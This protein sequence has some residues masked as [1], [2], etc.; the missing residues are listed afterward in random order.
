MNNKT[1]AAIATAQG[2]GGVGIIR[3]SGEYAFDIADKVFTSTSGKR[4][5]NMPG[6]TASF[7][8]V[9]DENGNSLE[10]IMLIFKKPHSYTGE[11]VVEI[12]CQGGVYVTKSI[13]RAILDNG[14]YPAEAGEFTKRAFLNGKMDL[15]EAESVM[16][17]ISAKNKTA[18]KAANSV[19]EGKLGK[20]LKSVKED[21]LTVAA[22]LSAW[23]DYPEDEIPAVNEEEIF[24]A[25]D[26]ASYALQTLIDE[27][28]RGRVLT[29][30]IDTVIVGKPNVGKSTLMNMLSGSE[31]SI[32]TDI[33][34]TTRDIVEDTVNLGSYTLHLSDT[35]GIRFTDDIIEKI[36]V[37][38]ALDKINTGELILAVFDGSGKLSEEDKH[39]IDKISN[40]NCIAI[41]NKSDLPQIIDN[42]YISQKI[43]HVVYTSAITQ[44]GAD[45]LIAAL[46]DIFSTGAFN[47]GE[48][49][50]AGERQRSTALSALEALI[51]AKTS[52]QAGYT[53][54]AVTVSIE[55]AIQE[56]LSLTGERATEEIVNKVF[57]RFCVGK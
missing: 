13:L 45:K 50:L 41:I 17:I 5:H 12:S 57:E 46:D 14:A 55:F 52:L 32:V 49:I 36:G 2:Q 16:N 27:C 20:R 54:D 53:L 44:E 18:V 6:Y 1:I 38:K 7:G 29:E 51:E 15:L 21:L 56:L 22:H 25:V 34:G 11:D 28:D 26:K 19:L 48:G 4:P 8:H 35:A 39:L 30:G 47:P 23:A 42:E 24:T 3:I 37:D 40:Y 9:S 33:P 31:R 10:A 43:P